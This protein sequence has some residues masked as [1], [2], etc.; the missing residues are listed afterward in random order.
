MKV[1]IFGI[2][3]L[4]FVGYAFVNKNAY[5]MLR[6]VLLAMVLQQPAVIIIGENGIGPQVITSAIFI[7]WY[8][9]F[10]IMQ[11][12][13]T[14]NIRKA[15]KIE[16]WSIFSC[17]FLVLTI[18]YSVLKNGINE[19]NQTF[20][21]YFLQLC[22]Y[23][24]CFIFIWKL[25][26]E[27]EIEYIHK[28]VKEIVKIVLIIGFVQF[29]NS[30]GII[31]IN[32]VLKTF[33]YNNTDM[34]L[35][36][37][38]ARYPWS[39]PRIYATFQ[40]PSY[41]SAFLV[42]TFYYFVAYGMTNKENIKIAILIL[43]EIFLTFSSTA[44]GAFAVSGISY[45]VISR[46]KKALKILIP[47]AILA[48]VTIVI[49]GNW[50]KIW[51]DVIIE[52]LDTTKS[53]SAWERNMWNENSIAAFKKSP[54][55]GVGY[56]NCRASY[57]IYSV[58]GQLG[59]IGCIF[60]IGMWIPFVLNALFKN[61]KVNISAIVLLLIG[62]ISSMLIAIPDI[63]FCVFWLA[64]YLL[65]LFFGIESKMYKRIKINGKYYDNYTNV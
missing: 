63:D 15:G 19:N 28:I 49:S 31:N 37:G 26:T 33:I 10:K 22:I 2:I 48:L 1:T 23:I 47:L 38:D 52:K 8:I 12:D 18:V 43:A 5:Y 58:L 16:T 44:Y 13:W 34:G 25:K 60:W 55:I 42:G 35:Q 6:A 59:I 27:F 30:C 24:I 3:W 62:V 11:N 32:S 46:N 36:M 21:L 14:I 7:I 64:M 56:K 40:E 65:A 54:M 57:I 20:L 51:N 53:G 39:T 9:V 61:S 41:C 29:V 4:L 45:L 17:I 50:S